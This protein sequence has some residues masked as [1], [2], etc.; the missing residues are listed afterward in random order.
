MTAL[1]DTS[2]LMERVGLLCWE[3]EAEESRT[4]SKEDRILEIVV[5]VPGVAGR[6][7]RDESSS[8]MSRVAS[9]S[10]SYG[11]NGRGRPSVMESVSHFGVT[12]AFPFW[13]NTRK[14]LG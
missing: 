4:A 14:K 6:E 8:P 11:L 3:A 10:A 2:D 1:E 13:R 7:S 12:I 5:G 9:L